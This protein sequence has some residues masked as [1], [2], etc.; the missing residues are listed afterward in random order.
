MVKKIVKR[1]LVFIIFA[2]CALLIWRVIVLSDKSKLSTLEITDSISQ[3]IKSGEAKVLTSDI[4]QELSASG[5]FCAYGLY[6]DPVSKELQITVRWN[7][8]IYKKS[9]SISDGAEFDFF[10]SNETSGNKYEVFSILKSDKNLMYNYRKLIFTG[11]EAEDSSQ[12][13]LT[14]KIPGIGEDSQTLKYDDQPFS[15]MMLNDSMLKSSK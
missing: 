14:M 11:V 12:I 10:I 13:S 3:T 1:V 2:I 8:S 15:E 7:D 4:Y 6:Y 5:Y 9:S